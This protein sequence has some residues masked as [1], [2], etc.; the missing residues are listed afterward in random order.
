ML[1]ANRFLLRP[2]TE[3]D[4]AAF[5][6][7]IVESHDEMRQWMPWAHAGYTEAEALSWFAHCAAEREQGRA[8]EFGIFH[9]ESQAFVG[10]CGLNQLNLMHGFCNLGYWVRR[11]ARRQGA[12]LS[13]IAALARH[14][15]ADLGLGRVE[16]VVANGNQASMAVA[17]KAG[18]RR[19][20]LARH[21]LK[22]HGEF[23]DA[24]VYSLVPSDMKEQHG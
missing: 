21:R 18:A 4:A 17:E 16:I 5:V 19:E 23:V 24:H 22:L 15:F 14:A 8:Y 12:A 1:R 3:K 6:A 10:G 11:S 13:A 20:C 9:A 2:Y 7:A